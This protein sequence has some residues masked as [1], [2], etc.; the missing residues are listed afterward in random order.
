[1]SDHDP[2]NFCINANPHRVCKPPH[3]VYLFNRMDLPGLK[4][5]MAEV[6][7]NFKSTNPE[8][9]STEEN[10]SFLKEEIIHAINIYV[11]SRMTKK[12]PDLPWMTL[13]IKR[14]L[15]KRERLIRAKRSGSKTSTAWETYKKQ[16]NKVTKTLIRN[17]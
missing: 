11:P 3:K 17:T 15:R 14:Q 6:A 13:T 2:V 12:K 10:W 16:R 1:M 8:S 5:H 9:R 7:T 4:K